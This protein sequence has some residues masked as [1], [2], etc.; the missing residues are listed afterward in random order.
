MTPS[1]FAPMPIT[2]PARS[3]SVRVMVTRERSGRLAVPAVSRPW[4]MIQL[5]RSDRRRSAK[6]STPLTLRLLSGGGLTSSSTRRPLGMVTAAPALGALPP[7]VA[8]S[9]QRHT[10]GPAGRGAGAGPA[11]GA[12][13][14]AGAG[15]PRA[16]WVTSR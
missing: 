8:G 7:Q 11:A 5:A 12:A 15:P 16:R 6:P 1:T 13:A 4:T 3:R 14:A 2:S 9:D 10:L